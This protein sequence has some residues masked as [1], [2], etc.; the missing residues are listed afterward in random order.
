MELD[1]SV[2]ATSVSQVIT[3]SL[4]H[5]RQS[6]PLQKW[7]FK[8]EPVIKIGRS[9]F[10]QVILHSAVVSRYH[11]ELRYQGRYWEAISL[12]HNGTYLHGHLIK[13]AL[14]LDG[15]VISLAISGPQL[16]INLGSPIV[17]PLL[18]TEAIDTPLTQQQDLDLRA[19]FIR[20]VDIFPD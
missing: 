5:P 10:N 3:L 7:T 6:I 16:K 1:S 19:T 8:N 14:V 12:G 4:R 11:L 2:L 13:R 20:E 9:P 15:M 17:K 18:K